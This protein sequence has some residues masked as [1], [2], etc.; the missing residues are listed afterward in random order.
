LDKRQENWTF[1][2]NMV[3]VVNKVDLVKNID[4]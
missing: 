2:T 3:K 4:G 1:I